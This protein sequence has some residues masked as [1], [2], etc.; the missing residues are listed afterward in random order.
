MSQQKCLTYVAI[1]DCKCVISA[2]HISTYMAT[3]CKN[4]RYRKFA[5]SRWKNGTSDPR[6]PVLPRHS[7]FSPNILLYYYKDNTGKPSNEH[8]LPSFLGFSVYH[9][10]NFDLAFSLDILVYSEPLVKGHSK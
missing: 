8:I 5:W 3:K 1:D 7:F 4:E 6:P 2:L 9:Y 10:M